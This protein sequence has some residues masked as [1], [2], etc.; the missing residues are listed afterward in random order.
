MEV[1]IGANVLGA[2]EAIAKKT[3]ERLSKL[4]IF[5]VNV[6]SSPG[7]GKTTILEKTC[8]L[9]KGRLRVG[10]IEGDITTTIDADRIARHGVP[11]HQINTFGGC[12]LDAKMVDKALGHFDLSQ[13]DLL[14]VENVGNLVCPADFELG[15][16][17][18]IVVLS[19]PEGD[20]KPSKYPVIFQKAGVLLLNKVD[21]LQFSNFNLD[22]AKSD[23]HSINPRLK[24]FET[25]GT[26]GQGFDV[27]CDWLIQQVDAKRARVNQG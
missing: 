3:G 19:V 4:G 10:V 2:N 16:D 26:T 23:L 17:C 1:K 8:E 14:I 27:W 6:I 9:L 24:V 15:E 18:K 22:K 5:C 7:A 13:L 11:V 25:V 12:H 21:M 20:D